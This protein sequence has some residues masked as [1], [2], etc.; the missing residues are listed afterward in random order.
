MSAHPNTSFHIHANATLA[1]LVECDQRVDLANSLQGAMSRQ[2][3]KQYIAEILVPACTVVKDAY[4]EVDQKIEISF[5]EG[6]V[7]FD[8]ASKDME[9]LVIKEEDEIKTS[10]LKTRV[11][12]MYMQCHLGPDKEVEQKNL[13]KLF[14]Q[15]DQLYNRRETL[16]TDLQETLKQSGR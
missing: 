6:I 7:A 16:W 11:S 4:T 5:A 3:F 2:S 14:I 15:L 10:Y 13:E 9:I 12:T 1:R 8:D